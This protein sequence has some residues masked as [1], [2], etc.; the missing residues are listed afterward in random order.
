MSLVAANFL[1]LPTL[2]RAGSWSKPG[3]RAFSDQDEA[4]CHYCHR[5]RSEAIS[6]SGDREIAASS[7]SSR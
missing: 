1:L 4:S 7:R 5:E 3:V 2:A 6:F